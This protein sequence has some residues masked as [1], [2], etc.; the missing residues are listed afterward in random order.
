MPRFWQLLA[1]TLLF[2]LLIH[3]DASIT[4]GR[5]EL[6]QL[7]LLSQHDRILVSDIPLECLRTTAAAQRSSRRKRGSRGGIRRRVRARGSKPPLPTII[8]S[9]VRALRNKVDELYAAT[10][11]LF[12]YRESCLLCF[13]ETWLN[14]TINDDSIALPG[15]GTPVRL[16]RD[17][18]ATG[19]S[20]GGGL[21]MYI[22]TQ[23]CKQYIIRHTISSPNLELLSVSLRPT[24]LPREF[25][26]LFVCL[27]YIPPDTNYKAA[28]ETIHQHI[29]DLETA[30]PDT[31][32]LILG[33]FNGCSMATALPH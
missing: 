30:S 10:Q 8:L 15:F 6:L 19:K 18:Q 13:C 27:V 20:I 2:L 28:A 21:C 24:Y 7:G 32:K 1:I 33:Y 29:Q 12:E 23:W 17:Q 26:Q 25:G 4:Y 22:N 9:N 5:E 11:H 3:T 14:N 31:P 16:D